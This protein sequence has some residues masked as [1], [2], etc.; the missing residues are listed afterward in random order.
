[1]AH[2][3]ATLDNINGHK[4]LLKQKPLT[5]SVQNA[6]VDLTGPFC[7]RLF[8]RSTGHRHFYSYVGLIMN[9]NIT[10]LFE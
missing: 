3:L 7:T 5:A 2:E 9:V 1:M 8:Q 10:F 6:N 4:C